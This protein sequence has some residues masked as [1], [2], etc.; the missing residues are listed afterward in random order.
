MAQ[1]VLIDTYC[2]LDPLPGPPFLARKVTFGID[3]RAWEID[4]CETH[5]VGMESMLAPWLAA[6]RTAGAASRQPH[7]ARRKRSRPQQEGDRTRAW[8]RSPEGQA[9][10]GGIRIGDRGR[11]PREVTAGYEAAAA[12]SAHQED[13]EGYPQ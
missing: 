7:P 13:Q 1:K 5:R 4:L 11:I 6:A 9:A 10:L 8:A 2:D 12:A 3:G